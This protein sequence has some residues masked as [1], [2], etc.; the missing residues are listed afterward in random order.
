MKVA[1]EPNFFPEWAKSPEEHQKD[2]AVF[3]K[4]QKIQTLSSPLFS[5]IPYGGFHK[6]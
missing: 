5:L 4:K 3:W 1:E 6:L 2:L